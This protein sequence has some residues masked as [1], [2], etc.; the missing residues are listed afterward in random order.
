MGIERRVE[1]RYDKC[2]D[3]PYIRLTIIDL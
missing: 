1:V 2:S 3:V